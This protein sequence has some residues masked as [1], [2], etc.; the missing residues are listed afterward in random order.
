MQHKTQPNVKALFG[1]K[2]QQTKKTQKKTSSKT[3]CSTCGKAV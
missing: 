1:H 2:N 3:I